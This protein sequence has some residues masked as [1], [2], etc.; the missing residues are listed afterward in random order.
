MKIN[1]KSAIIV[2]CIFA[3]IYIG[4]LNVRVSTDTII[5]TLLPIGLIRGNGFDLKELYPFAAEHL[6]SGKINNGVHYYILKKNNH[7]ISTF[8]IFSSILAVPIY[9]IPVIYKN[10]NT[11]NM[12][13]NFVLILT[14]GKISAGIFSAI[15]ATFVFLSLKHLTRKTIMALGLTFFYG[16]GTTTLSISS[17]SLWQHAASQMML[18]ICMYFFI[19][20][21]NKRR[22][23][24][25]CGLFL[26]I[27]TLCRFS[28]I[29]IALAFFTYICAFEKKQIIGFIKYALLPV[30]FFAWYQITYPGNLFFYKYESIGENATFQNSFWT[31]FFGLLIAPSKGLFIYSPLFI[32]TLL[33]IWI[34]I[35]QKNKILIFFAISSVI[36]ISFLAKWSDWH[37]GWSY[38]PRMLTD[39]TPFLTILISPILTYKKYWRKNQIK[40]VFSLLLTTSVFIHLLGVSVA[41]F[42]WYSLQTKNLTLNQAHQAKFLWNWDLPEIYY[43]YLTTGGL[44]KIS[45]IFLSEIANMLYIFTRYFAPIIVLLFIVE[46]LKIKINNNYKT[47]RTKLIILK[48]KREHN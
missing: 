21:K 11:T 7:L 19:T 13:N 2:F 12:D 26:G 29:V 14:L 42:S 6:P 5:T 45:E 35:K 8:P 24:S 33:G 17:Q 38:G 47:P 16:L 43:F 32:F 44:G 34:A 40:I 39:L 36:Y 20:A 31:G 27:A 22:F 37:G 10:I 3:S 9:L 48:H 23:Y 18:S 28:N 4:T 46:I 41:N 1:F 30:L 15:S 25:K